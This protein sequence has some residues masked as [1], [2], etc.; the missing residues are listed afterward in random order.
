MEPGLDPGPCTSKSSTHSLYTAWPPLIRLTR[1]A[2]AGLGLP[3]QLQFP[4]LPEE[5]AGS[6]Q[7]CALFKPKAQ[8][9][10]KPFTRRM[11]KN[12]FQ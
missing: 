2:E 7:V 6:K 4:K 5:E 9:G 1:S 12:L 8:M 3:I 11:G 10:P